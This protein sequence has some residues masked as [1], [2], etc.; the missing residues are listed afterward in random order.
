MGQPPYIG[1]K[2]EVEEGSVL[3]TFVITAG[4]DKYIERCLRTLN[5][6]INRE[7]HRII[8]IEAPSKDGHPMV[9]DKVKDYIDIYVKTEK[10][11]GFCKS[12]NLGLRWV[13]TPYFTVVHDDVW[14]PHT[15]WWEPLQEELDADEN[16]IMLQPTQ[17]N[18]REKEPLPDT[19]TDGEYQQ[20]LDE[21]HSQSVTEIYCMV[22]KSEWLTEIGYFD[23][24]IYPVGPEDLEFFRQSRSVDRRIA[25][26]RQSVVYHKGVGRED[27]RGG[28]RIDSGTHEFM[29]AKWSGDPNAPVG[30][31]TQGDQRQPKFK[32]LI[33]QL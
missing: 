23:E 11:Y 20:L 9:Y 8:F 28:P 15:G 3:N 24:R 7:Q 14:F 1:S 30:G 5:E 27:A 32:S 31:L 12:I 13:Y 21:A 33:K 18:R 2:N 25:V 4:H 16:L 17:R 22:F 29:M 19:L 10:N 26:S 6:T